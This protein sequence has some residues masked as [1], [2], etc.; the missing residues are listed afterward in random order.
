[1][2]SCQRATDD[3]LPSPKR[4][5]AQQTPHPI[6][7]LHPL[8]FSS[9]V[10]LKNPEY[11]QISETASISRRRRLYIAGRRRLVWAGRERLG[12]VICLRVD[13]VVL[14]RIVGTKISTAADDAVAANAQHEEGT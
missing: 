8:L 9:L 3:W 4:P 1:L 2:P 13:V 11:G 7:P 10:C 6:P 5:A 12:D 14:W